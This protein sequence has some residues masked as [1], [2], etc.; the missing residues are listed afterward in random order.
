MPLPSSL[1]S[2]DRKVSWWPFELVFSFSS[3]YPGVE[4]LE[5]MVVLLL[6]FDK[7]LYCSPQWLYQFTLPPTVHEIP[8]SPCL[9]WH[10]VSCLFDNNHSERC[11]VISRCIFDS[12]FCKMNTVENLFL[13]VYVCMHVCIYFWLC[14]VFVAPCGL[15]LVAASRGYSLLW[16]MGFSLWWLLLLQSAGS[17]RVGFSSS[18][19][20]IWLLHGTLNLPRPGIEPVSPELADGSWSTVPPGKS[21]H[22]FLCLLVTCMSLECLFRSSAHVLI[23]FLK[24]NVELFFVSFGY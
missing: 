13:R 20:G 8:F 7:P 9:H 24:K 21:E 14:W 16:C 1:Q 23:S 6:A 2:F 18:G 22:L 4:L 10:V 5:H 3:S 11:E 19:T 17:R 12:N 15:S